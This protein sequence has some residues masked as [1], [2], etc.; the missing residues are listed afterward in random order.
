MVHV[1]RIVLAVARALIRR[2]GRMSVALWLLG[3][4]LCRHDIVGIMLAKCGGLGPVIPIFS[5]FLQ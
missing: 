4:T 1:N 2:L 3:Q 5:E